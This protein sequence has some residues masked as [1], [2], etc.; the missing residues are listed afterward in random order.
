MDPI[1]VP[2]EMDGVFLCIFLHF[3]QLLWRSFGGCY[4]RLVIFMSF[5]ISVTHFSHHENVAKR[6]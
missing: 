1:L 5:M 6:A 3:T 2:E 4:G